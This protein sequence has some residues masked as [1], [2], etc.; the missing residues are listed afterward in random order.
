MKKLAI[1]YDRASREMQKDNWSRK[2][3]EHIGTKLAQQHGFA[4]VEALTEVES[5]ESL[6]NRPVM[7]DILERAEVGLIGAIIVQN[8]SRLTRDEDGLDG[9]TIKKICKD[10][11]VLI[12]TPGKVYD[13]GTDQDDKL[14]DIE[15][16]VARWYKAELMKFTAQ[17]LKARAREG[18]YMGGTP[19][20][21]YRL[22]YHQSRES[23]KP[24]ADLAID[25]DEARTVQVMFD[26]Y[27]NQRL[28]ANGTAKRLNELGYQY[29][30]Q[31]RRVRQFCTQDILRLI[32]SE[33][34]IGFM[35]W[36][37]A[38]HGRKSK[39]LQD[40]EG[41]YVHRSDL[42][43][44]SVKL[45]EQAQ[46]IRKSRSRKFKYNISRGQWSQYAFT[47][48]CGCPNCGGGLSA[49]KKTNG[50]T[51]KHY[52]RY[53]CAAHRA[54]RINCP[55]FS[56]SE[57]LIA[58]ALIPFLADTVNQFIDIK[59]ALTQA[60]QEHG[61]TPLEDNIFNDVQAEIMATK[62][63]QSRI[64]D[65]IADGILTKAEAKAKMDEL[66]AKLE[67]LE[68]K[69]IDIQRKDEIRKD[70]LEALEALQGADIESKFWEMLEETPTILKR[71]LDLFFVH[72]SIHVVS[73]GSGGNG[74]NI[75]GGHKSRVIAYEYTDD[76]KG[77]ICNESRGRIC[78]PHDRANGRRHQLFFHRQRPG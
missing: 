29:R 11:S 13:F 20:F 40:F 77:L 10:N 30:G 43:I 22:V 66:R 64:I 75:K 71:V 65:S 5:G 58:Q 47:G 18:K 17:G 28:G 63:A 24:T 41:T 31:K 38:K 32:R 14:S 73:S 57:K 36:G 68:R 12:I 25:E 8:F 9:L 48:V 42:Q 2:D 45:W 16:M 3:A 60:A 56:I 19:T 62:E 69:L 1:I 21:G 44:I 52:V 72:G 78:R 50:R 15:L 26:L 46:E 33:L 27:V 23:E 49:H 37:H 59:Q 51:N 67:R 6:L 7:K 4:R 61:Q 70:Y 53:F 55:G 34:Y 76:F 74:G 54:K 39:Y 35:K